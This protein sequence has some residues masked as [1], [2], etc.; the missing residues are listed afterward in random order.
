MTI[1]ML[2]CASLNAAS[3]DIDC[4]PE[5]NLSFPVSQNKNSEGPQRFQIERALEY[6]K[7]IMQPTVTTRLNKKLVIELDWENPKVN[8]S[9][10]RDNLNNPVIQLYGG[11]T[12]HPELTKDGLIGIL[13]HELG[14]H[15]GG[16]PKKKRGNTN[17]RSWSSAEGQADY[18]AGNKCLPLFYN[19][20][21][22]SINLDK[23]SNKKEVDFAES[24]C[25]NNP[26]CARTAL[27][28]LSMARVF[29]SLK[30]FNKMPSIEYN[31]HTEVWETA[32]SH[33]KPQCRLDT[34]LSGAICSVPPSQPFDPIDPDVG[35]CFR[36]GNDISVVP[37][38]RP[39]CWFN[40]ENH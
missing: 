12:R 22:E 33:P 4:F 38:E 31:D 24:R 16:A 11:M 34:I 15:L 37:G 25:G 32:F 13:C 40:P 27:T 9:A 2:T 30:T 10:T 35:A 28:G 18:F 29:A 3:N 26:I 21:S 17:K 5:N 23:L 8:A 19:N 39:R 7:T 14:H 20:P 6:F 36:D 1:T